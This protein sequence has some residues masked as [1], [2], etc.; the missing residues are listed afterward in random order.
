M[1]SPNPQKTSGH[2]GEVVSNPGTLSDPLNGSNGGLHIPIS[3]EGGFYGYNDE[4]HLQHVSTPARAHTL[5]S[6]ESA[7]A[8]G[9]E[10]DRPTQR[11]DSLR[12]WEDRIQVGACHDFSYFGHRTECFGFSHPEG[13]RV[14]T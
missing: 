5:I 4:K 6:N 11:I 13:R 9:R 10:V 3:D 2:F 7:V 12:R 14:E 8:D 1:A